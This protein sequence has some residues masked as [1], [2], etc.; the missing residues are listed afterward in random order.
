MSNG[1]VGTLVVRAWVEPDAGSQGLRA[2]VLAVSGQ[3]ADL[4]EIGVATGM[5]AILG[6]VEEALRALA[7]FDD[8]T[9]RNRPAP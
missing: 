1:I 8:G 4:R 3:D 7:P 6:L 9:E 2:R 5:P